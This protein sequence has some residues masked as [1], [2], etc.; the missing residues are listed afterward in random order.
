LR[1]RLQS[2]AAPRAE[3]PAIPD[4]LRRR[5]VS[6]FALAA[7]TAL[8]LAGSAQAQERAYEIV[9]PAGQS[10]DWVNLWTADPSGEYVYYDLTETSPDGAVP[11][12]VRTDSF[13]ARREADGWSREWVTPYC[14]GGRSVFDPNPTCTEAQE[15]GGV[16]FVHGRDGRVLFLTGTDTGGGDQNDHHDA[17]FGDPDGVTLLSG[18]VSGVTGDGFDPSF[19][20]PAADLSVVTFMTSDPLLPAD[21]DAHDDIYAY[22]NGTLTLVTA[23]TAGEVGTCSEVCSG[24]TRVG[25]NDFVPVASGEQLSGHGVSDDGEVIFFITP[26]QLTP[27]DADEES[28]LYVRDDAGV[29]LL[30]PGGRFEWAAADGSVVFAATA[31]QLDPVADVDASVDVYSIDAST[32]AATLVSSGTED[33]DA[34]LTLGSDDGSHAWFVTSEALAGAPATTDPKLYEWDG[35]V[36]YV[37]SLPEGDQLMETLGS[38]PARAATDGSALVFATAAQLDPGDTNS[39]ADV[40]RFAGGSL[41]LL[42][43][44][45]AGADGAPIFLGYRARL[46]PLLPSPVVGRGITADG[47]TAF[48]TTAAPLVE[49]D[50]DQGRLDIYEVSADGTAELVTPPG[51][52]PFDAYY[53]QNTPDGTDVFFTTGEQLVPWDLDGTWDDVYDARRG[54]G[55]AGPPPIEP[56]CEGDAC[57]GP[58]AGDPQLQSPAVG[59]GGDA[60]PRPRTRFS[61]PAFSS[62]QIARLARGRKVRVAVRVS[63]PATVRVVLRGRL[64]RRSGVLAHGRRTVAAAGRADVPVR[65]SRRARAALRRQGRLRLRLQISVSG[66]PGSK[67]RVL[68]LHAT[69]TGR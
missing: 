59:D 8:A 9:T 24:A 28:D 1:A 52:A 37:A 40:Y 16:Q 25:L 46:N 11:D 65:L 26:K 50:T 14:T 15:R 66:A 23:N 4:R 34:K 57:Q 2:L 30:V 31:A 36:T 47:E 12:G 43:P 3:G 63:G 62:R 32:G 68:T 60:T 10:A 45:P 58:L 18:D 55:F 5:A 49:E 33:V 21:D 22:E 6:T 56:E 17:F 48:V 64:G 29:R 54:G 20:A 19:V 61:A 35:S 7:L 67:A 69:R 13:A 38:R 27:E 44:R 53:R 51:S 39:A 41:D 42:T